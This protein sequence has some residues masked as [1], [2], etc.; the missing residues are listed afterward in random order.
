[1]SHAGGS[2]CPLNSKNHVKRMKTFLTFHRVIKNGNDYIY[3][4]AYF[5]FE[6]PILHKLF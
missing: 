1:M 4:H 5:V 2:K 6:L 3:L